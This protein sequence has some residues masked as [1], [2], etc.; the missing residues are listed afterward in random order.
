[1]PTRILTV[2]DSKT[3]R[4]II[5]RAFKS[6]DCE[7]LEAANGVEGLAVASREK[8]DVIILDVTMP[9]MDG[10]EM[11]SR[12]KSNAELRSIPVLMLTAEAGRDNVLRIA[13]L[14]VRDYLVKPFKEDQIIER[15]G[16]V[17]ELKSRGGS[18]SKSRKRYDEP[19]N[20]MLVDDKTAILDQI[21]NGLSDTTWKVESQA[22]PQLALEA[23][24]T[25]MPDL[26]LVSLSLPDGAGF[27]L[28]QKLRGG[29]KTEKLPI[30]GLCVKTAAED[31][32]RAQQVGFTSIITKPIDFTEMKLKISRLL[33][34]D[35]SHK[36]FTQRDGV[37]TL[38]VPTDFNATVSHD[39]GASL[40][41]K[42]TEAVDA[43]FNR[44]V[45]DISQMKSV[46]LSLIELCL[47]VL[48]VAEDLALKTAFICTP[49]LS[50]AFKNYEESK[51]WLFAPTFEEAVQ[52]L[53]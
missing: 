10:T 43:G 2:D 35:A 12:L 11:L 17:V 3:I 41:E 15:I 39:I 24:T 25:K 53:N 50:A 5:A 36:Y 14:G 27:W 44:M 18:S 48:K 52:M 26:L 19:L 29:I 46:E 23:I 21:R 42:V 9:I 20:I 8:P 13:K 33:N 22:H 40:N 16:R 51:E 6:Y 30:V 31:Q 7:I 49:E 4:L 45:L 37:L 38:T 32:A 28:F 1:M 47:N 34:L